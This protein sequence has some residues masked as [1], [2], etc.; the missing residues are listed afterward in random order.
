MKIIKAYPPNFADIKQTFPHVVG[1]Q[2]VLYAWGD[3][4]FNPSGGPVAQ[5]LRAHEAVH[6]QQQSRLEG[7]VSKWWFMYLRSMAFRY[8]M[9][10]P[11]HVTEYRTYLQNKKDKKGR[12]LQ[13]IAERLSG[14]LYGHLVDYETALQ[15]IRTGAEQDDG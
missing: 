5:W 3:R 7:G 4:V 11:A 2:G 10:V 6:L 9:E 14:P 15:T 1:L 8:L 12:Y 13:S